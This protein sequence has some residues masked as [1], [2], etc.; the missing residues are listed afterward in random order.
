M[1]FSTGLIV[2]AGALVFTNCATQ[3]SNP[4]YQQTT[5]YKGS[6]PQSAI[7]R[8]ASYQ[9]QTAAPV[10]YVTDGNSAQ[11]AHYTQ[12]TQECLSKESTRKVIGS[13]AGGAAG[14]LIGRKLSGDNKTIGTIAGAALGSAAGYGIADKSI[15][16]S[17]TSIPVNSQSA[18]VAPIYQPSAQDAQVFSASTPQIYTTNP[19]TNN[20]PK[21]AI[22]ENVTSYGAEGTPGFYAVQGMEMNVPIEKNA[23]TANISN[24]QTQIPVQPFTPA[25]T[26]STVTIIEPATMNFRFHTVIPGDTA[27]SIA[28]ASCV[29]VA[30]LKRTNNLNDQYYIRVGDEITI[31]AS[32]CV[33]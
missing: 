30:E 9:T 16:C 33:D 5:K 31:P 22:E 14:A 18:I 28:R 23:M 19:Q 26:T 10:R 8:Q 7:I 20:I 24:I 3:Q 17:P 15:R 2:I 11:S 27:Y 21:S 6:N 12:V 32:N 4:I 1:R 13:L 25:P 29:S